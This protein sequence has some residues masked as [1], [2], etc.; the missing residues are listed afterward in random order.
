MNRRG[1]AR[2]CLVGYGLASAGDVVAELRGDQ[3]LVLA[4]PVIL[5][6]LL[7]GYLWWSSP[8]SPLALATMVALGFS[9]LGDCLGQPMLIKIIFFLGA[10]T[11]YCVAFW[12]GRRRGLLSRPG[13]LLAYSLGMIGLIGLVA[14]QA[15]TLWAPVVVYGASLV[16]MVALASGISRLTLIGALLFVASD[17]AIAYGAFLSPPAGELNGA[18]IMA[19]YLTAQLLLVVGPQQRCAARID[20]APDPYLAGRR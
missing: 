18:L 13:P 10:Q 2:T 5:M 7:A 11:A 16:L 15:A 8:R 20:P 9:W 6:P 3:V 4:L 17:L 19:T 14:S 12:P 1:L